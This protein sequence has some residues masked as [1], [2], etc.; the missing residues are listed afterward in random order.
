VARAAGVRVATAPIGLGPFTSDWWANCVADIL[1]PNTTV[2]RDDASVLYC[3][4]YGLSVKRRQ[5]DGFRIAE[6]LPLTQSNRSP[7][8]RA[9]R[10]GVN[11]FSQF[12]SIR[13]DESKAWWTAL[14]ESLS[15]TN[16]ILEG[17]CFH[18]SIFDDFA[19]TSECFD[20]AGLDPRSVRGPDID[21]R[22]A[23]ARLKDFDA[24]VTSRFHAVVVGNA[25]GIP[26]FAVCDGEYYCRKME[27]AAKGFASST[28]MRQFDASPQEAT[29]R[30]LKS[31]ESPA[32][33]RTGLRSVAQRCQHALWRLRPA[34]IIADTMKRW[35]RPAA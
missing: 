14:L 34:S 2:V 4:Q 9:K 28:Q 25:F 32:T 23:C 27:A 19:I 31:V 1:R 35:K 17:F 10:I 13:H 11:I 8:P 12:G 30:I 26:T 24:I 21:F 18:N 3:K 5:D 16:V 29:T 20:R 7:E 6:V 33:L 15:A 22:V